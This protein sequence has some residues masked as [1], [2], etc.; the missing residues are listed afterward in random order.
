MLIDNG[1]DLALYFSKMASKKDKSFFFKCSRT[2]CD[3]YLFILLKCTQSTNRFYPMS[4]ETISIL[5][6]YVFPDRVRSIINVPFS[7]AKI[8]NPKPSDRLERRHRHDMLLFLAGSPCTRNDQKSPKNLC[9]MACVL[10][11]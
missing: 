1:A 9:A 4:N 11:P 10:T 8:R 6:T 3:P 2:N 5:S 7:L